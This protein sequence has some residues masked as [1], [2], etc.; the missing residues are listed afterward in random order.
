MTTF[1]LRDIPQELYQQIKD[2]AAREGR[3]VNQQILV[4]LERSVLL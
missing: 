4:L 3:S 1:T 2:M